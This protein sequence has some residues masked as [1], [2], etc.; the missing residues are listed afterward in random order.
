MNINS[1]K[2][3][4]L[5]NWKMIFPVFIILA[6]ILGIGFWFYM[7]NVGGKVEVAVARADINMDEELAI[8]V[9]VTVGEMQV[10]S[11]YHDTIRSS[12]QL[13][14][15]SAKGFIPKGTVLRESMLQPA[16][17]PIARLQPGN[18]AV[19]VPNTI[20]TTIADVVKPGNKVRVKIIA[21]ASAT[22][23]IP[24][25]EIARIEPVVILAVNEKGV[26]V[27]LDEAGAK[28]LEEA[29]VGYTID[30]ELL[31]ARKGAD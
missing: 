8:P 1:G 18:V 31:P 15:K 29:K 10:G 24:P 3:G 6:L 7:H 11:L 27:S 12:A 30:F 23:Q 16:A 26:V 20:N 28:T 22:Q 4:I 19:S 5:S 2:P 25:L 17:G 14:G 21:K 9:N 13:K